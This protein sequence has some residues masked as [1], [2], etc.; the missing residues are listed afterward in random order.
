MKDSD[1]L[2]T[3]FVYPYLHVPRHP[4]LLGVRDLPQQPHMHD[5]RHGLKIPLLFSAWY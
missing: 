5:S 2:H 1:G 4:I 3:E